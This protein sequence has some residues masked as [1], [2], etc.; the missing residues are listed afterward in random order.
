[1]DNTDELGG[2]FLET[3]ACNRAF[4]R[5][6]RNYL[7]IHIVGFDEID[8]SENSLSMDSSENS[9]NGSISKPS[10]VLQKK[11]EGKGIK[12]FEDFK[13]VLRE[14]WKNGTY[15]N[16]NAKD[17]NKYD[18]IPIKECRKLLLLLQN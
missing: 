7:G 16:D 14:M 9:E 17:W 12:S 15:K 18:D 5:C 6:V 1:V 4:V 10:E 8:K 11:A 13:K 2:K 3:M